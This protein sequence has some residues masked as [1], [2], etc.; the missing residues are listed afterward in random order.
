[1][2]GQRAKTKFHPKQRKWRSGYCPPPRLLE[3]FPFSGPEP[4]SSSQ[5]GQQ[6]DPNSRY[7]TFE[8]A[9]RLIQDRPQPQLRTASRRTSTRSISALPSS[10]GQVDSGGDD[11]AGGFDFGGDVDGFD[12]GSDDVAAGEIPGWVVSMQALPSSTG[13]PPPSALPPWLT[14]WASARGPTSFSMASGQHDFFSFN[15]FRRALF[16]LAPLLFF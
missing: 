2:C 5:T 16:S 15:K 11:A 4:S 6:Q 7:V 8:H 13:R 1:M 3:P 9:P 10:T 14:W 12:F